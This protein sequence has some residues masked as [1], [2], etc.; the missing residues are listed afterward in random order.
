MERDLILFLAGAGLSGFF[1]WLC[2]H[3]YYKKSLS[4]QQS[5]AGAQISRL[6]D[7]L[8]AQNATDAELLRQ[9][10]TEESVAEY[11]RAGTPVRVI[12][13]YADLNSEEKADLFDTV[14]LRVKGRK[15]NYNKYRGT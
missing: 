3:I 11:K 1:S 5:A 6:M 12:D 4:T 2:T 9:R 14:M 10:R 7:A 8:A 15:P 13:T